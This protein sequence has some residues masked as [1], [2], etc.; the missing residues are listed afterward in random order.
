MLL[1]LLL[2][3][4]LYITNDLSLIVPAVVAEALLGTVHKNILYILCVILLSF[5]IIRIYII[6]F[7]SVCRRLQGG[8]EVCGYF[9]GVY[10]IE[11]ED[12]LSMLREGLCK[13]YFN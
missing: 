11:A 8:Y 4:S 1:L 9:I 10:N 6:L 12:Y 13:L 2:Q 5:Y 3:K 7:T